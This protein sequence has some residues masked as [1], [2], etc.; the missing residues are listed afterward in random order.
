MKQGIRQRLTQENGTWALSL[1]YK[2][3]KKMTTHAPEQ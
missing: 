1:P 3:G 2:W